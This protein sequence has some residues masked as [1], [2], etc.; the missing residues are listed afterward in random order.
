MSDEYGLKK[1]RDRQYF[2][3]QFIWSGFDY[4]GEPTPYNQ[5][6]VKTSSFGTIDTAGFPKDA[7]YVFQSQW[8]S[9]PMV[10]LL[11]MNWTDYKPGQNVQVWAYSN[12]KS[13]ELFLNGQSLGTKSFDAKTSADGVD[14][15]ETTECSKDD[16][17]Y[18]TGTC[19]G[20]Y[21]SPNGSSGKLHLTWN[22]PFQPGRLVA[23]ARDG[24]GQQVARDEVDTAGKPYTV[25]L[26]PDKT[27]LAADGKSLS[28]VTAD[29][30]D[31][32]GVVVPDAAN[33]ITFDVSGAGSFV[34]ADN[35][36]EDDAEGYQATTHDAFNGK[37][38]AIVEARQR[39]GLVTITAT[40]DGLAPT[41]TTLHVVAAA[42]PV[43]GPEPDPIDRTFTPP[44]PPTGPV[45]DAGYSGSPSSVPA[46]LLDGN[47]ASGGWSNAYNKSA[48][49]TLPAVSLAHENEWVSVTWPSARQ[50]SSVVP[51]FTIS[52]SRVLPSALTVSY[53]NGTDWVAT[54]SQQ[55][56][57]AA[58]SNQPTTV[59]FD[60]VSTTAIRLDL[61]SPAPNTSTGFMQITELQTP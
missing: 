15:L 19:P 38:L 37:V 2:A 35:G 7:Y 49:N 36:K 54:T 6:P 41:T 22:V 16:K 20:S 45:A 32:H 44:P 28:Y 8:T 27:M 39:P 42:T 60:P 50:V 21:E 3:G 43:Q 58:A 18:T 34:G 1:D 25:R 23:V 48:T 40:G 56:Q 47:T 17:N 33:A 46:G 59:T 13:V 30:V 53:W 55:V 24:D 14:Y 11:P 52:T 57:F 31:E 4:I 10:H 9:R 26:S 12:V 61:T 51:Y 29:V 5:F